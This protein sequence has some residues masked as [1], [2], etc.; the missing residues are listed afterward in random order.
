MTDQTLSAD[1]TAEENTVLRF[2]PIQLVHMYAKCAA[3]E[4]R[5]TSNLERKRLKELTEHARKMLVP[6]VKDDETWYLGIEGLVEL[7]KY[8]QEKGVSETAENWVNH[9]SAN[10]E[11]ELT[12]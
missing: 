6:F 5:A 4:L 11:Q 3:Q 1:L 10:I 9:L 7:Y 12:V 2:K 8:I